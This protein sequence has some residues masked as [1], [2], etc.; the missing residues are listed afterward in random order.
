[1]GNMKKYLKSLVIL[2]LVASFPVATQ[3]TSVRSANLDE[4]T[5]RATVIVVGKITE[6][7][8]VKIQK[9]ALGLS[10]E[11]V[12]WT[13]DPTEVLKGN[14]SDTEPFSWRQVGKPY[15]IGGEYL[16]MLLHL[17]KPDLWTPVGWMQG[18]F[19]I[20]EGE[21]GEKEILKDK[22]DVATVGKAVNVNSESTSLQSLKDKIKN[23]LEN[24]K[25]QS[26]ENK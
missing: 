11:V 23:S 14:I 15:E 6:K 8:A 5:K 12:T 7:S 24:S 18:R 19:N 16:L 4:M 9:D 22:T 3:A 1:M 26:G 17:E 2:L 21:N 20:V 10:R 25:A 13:I